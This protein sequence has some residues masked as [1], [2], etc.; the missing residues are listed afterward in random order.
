MNFFGVKMEDNEYANMS[1]ELNAL[2]FDEHDDRPN[3]F[4]VAHHICLVC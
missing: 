2:K 3:A 4:E 1:H